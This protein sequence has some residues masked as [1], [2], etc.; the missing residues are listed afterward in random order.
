MST[1]DKAVTSTPT[2]LVVSA[3]AVLRIQIGLCLLG[4][5][6]GFIG[7][8]DAYIRL[9]GHT[10]EGTILTVAIMVT[11][12]AVTATLIASRILVRRAT[13]P[14]RHTEGHLR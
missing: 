4:I 3:R 1:P 12:T 6:V 7:L 2:H 14:A 9:G 5:A 8:R 10:P 13:R 11:L